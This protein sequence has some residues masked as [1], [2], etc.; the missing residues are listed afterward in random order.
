MPEEGTNRMQC[1][2]FEALLPEALDGLLEGKNLET[3]QTHSRGCAV[4]GP[5]LAEAQ[6]GLHWLKSLQEVD[7]PADLLHNVLVATSGV[8]ETAA[9]VKPAVPTFWSRLR[10]FVSPVF[11]PAWEVVRQPRFAMSFGAAFFSISIALNIAGVHVGNVKKVDLRPSAMVRGYYATSA[12]V[13]R[14]YENIRF[15]YE[16]ESRLRDLKR[17]SE[18]EPQQPSN[19]KE[20]K[21]NSLG[22]PDDR[23]DQNYSRQDDSEP[24]LAKSPDTP[25]C[26]PVRSM[27]RLV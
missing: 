6:A 19:E 24:L 4:C 13:V 8:A 3:F 21:S 27:R 16:I 20:H 12:R 7:P 26:W 14:Y 9:A 23:H 17:V 11:A 25:L 22:S 5:M 18:P 10:D 2:E 15:V 1:T